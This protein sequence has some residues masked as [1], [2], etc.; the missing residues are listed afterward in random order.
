MPRTSLI[1]VN[2]N[3]CHNVK[4]NSYDRAFMIKTVNAD[5]KLFPENIIGHGGEV[6]PSLIQTKDLVLYHVRFS[7]LLHFH[8]SEKTFY[9]QRHH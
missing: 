4:L 8:L 5:V 2:E 9:R 6:T 1:S 3:K 7:I